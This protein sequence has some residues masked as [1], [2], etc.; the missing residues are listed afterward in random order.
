M[1]PGIVSMESVILIRKVARI[2]LRRTVRQDVS[3]ISGQSNVCRA[4]C[5]KDCKTSR[6]LSHP[7]NHVLGSDQDSLTCHEV[8]PVS[9]PHPII[10]ELCVNMVG[11]D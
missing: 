4:N 8:L 11:S 10:K 6:S 5:A 7:W 2:G 9:T 3:R 1:G